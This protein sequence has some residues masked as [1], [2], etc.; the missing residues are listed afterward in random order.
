MRHWTQ[1]IAQFSKT[2]YNAEFTSLLSLGD[3]SGES[4]FEV[5]FIYI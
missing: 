5:G 4:V 3:F 2:P 1:T